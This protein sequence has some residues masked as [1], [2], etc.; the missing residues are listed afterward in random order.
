M[1][2]VSRSSGVE[3]CH[4]HS[5]TSHQQLVNKKSMTVRLEEEDTGQVKEHHSADEQSST[6]TS[7]SLALLSLSYCSEDA[8]ETGGSCSPRPSSPPHSSPVTT[9]PHTSAV[10]A[11]HKTLDS[12][13]GK[14]RCNTNN[15]NS[16][17]AI[18]S[19]EELMEQGPAF[20][21]PSLHAVT[22]ACA[23]TRRQLLT[24][25]DGWMR[26]QLL[27]T[28]SMTSPH[29]P[30]PMQPRNN[31]GILHAKIHAEQVLASHAEHVERVRYAGA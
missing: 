5:L 1:R 25:A 26:R 19:E 24:D 14:A 29:T 15:S 22:G 7:R 6:D 9:P 10:H 31:E 28:E 20:R 27:T 8:G 21:E 16:S 3:P 4:T 23:C 13:I 17:E 18:W 11:P 2:L 30:L 12:T